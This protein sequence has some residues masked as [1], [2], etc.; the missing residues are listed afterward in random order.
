VE[1]HSEW[2]WLVWR[3]VAP[4]TR[5]FFDPQFARNVAFLHLRFC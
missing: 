5:A 1:W 4:G 2:R 3:D